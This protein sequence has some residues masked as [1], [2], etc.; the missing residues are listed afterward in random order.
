MHGNSTP[1]HLEQIIL[2][3]AHNWQASYKEI[4]SD[5]SHAQTLLDILLLSYQITL[6][7]CKMLHAKL[8]AQEELHKIYTPS[9]TDSWM[10]NLK[11]INN[12]TNT[13]ELA[14]E[15]IKQSQSQIQTIFNNFKNLAPEIVHMNPQPTQTLIHDLKQAL[16]LWGQ[17]QHEFANHLDLVQ[18]EFCL[19]ITTISDV[20]TIL[21]NFDHAAEFKNCHLKEAAGHLAKTTKDIESVF[22]RI[23][24]IRKVIIERMQNFFTQ[25]FKIYYQE[26]VCIVNPS[27]P[28][29]SINSLFEQ[30]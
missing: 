2:K 7:S 5:G 11:F 26:L 24:H 14:I 1:N 4:L 9:L 21:H 17:E 3:Q 18:H 16:M 23:I 13:L 6:E 15:Q 19:A 28:T 10:T 27:T 20:K 8:Q 30:Y 29:A 12:D 25:F 22:L